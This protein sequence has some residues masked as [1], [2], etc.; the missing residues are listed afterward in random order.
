MSAECAHLAN[1]PGDTNTS[2]PS[3]FFEPRAFGLEEERRFL[4]GRDPIEDD[5]FIWDCYQ[6]V[7]R[8]ENK[9]LIIKNRIPK[10]TL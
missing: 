2:Q 3:S 10:K 5:A 8:G 7:L 1:L 4:G 6:V 9:N